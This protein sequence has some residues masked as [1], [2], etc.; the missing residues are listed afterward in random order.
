MTKARESIGKERDML[1]GYQKKC[2]WQKIEEVNY[3]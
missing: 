1:Y 2:Q 3:E